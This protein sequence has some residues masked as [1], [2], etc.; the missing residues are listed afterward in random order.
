MMQFSAAPWKV[1]SKTNALLCKEAADLHKA[2]SK[3]IYALAK[4]SSKTGE[5]ITRYMEYEFPHQGFAGVNDQFMLGE[6]ILVAPVYEKNKTTRKV[7]L[8]K[9]NWAYVNGE[10]YLGGEI[11]EIK[12]PLNII[13]YF[14]KIK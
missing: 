13:P 4:H 8:P 10:T 9:G 5:P 3:D 12:A 2:F 11:V 7:H 1:L 14:K 6:N